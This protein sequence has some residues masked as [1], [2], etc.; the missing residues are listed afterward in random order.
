MAYNTRNSFALMHR[1]VRYH[2]FD[3]NS[4]KH[5]FCS[6]IKMDSSN[7]APQKLKRQVI[8]YQNENKEKK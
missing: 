4:N 1:K 2:L 5:R 8:K 7:I 3:I 6:L